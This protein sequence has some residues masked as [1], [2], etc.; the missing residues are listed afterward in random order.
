[1]YP[2]LIDA[3]RDVKPKQTST[4]LLLF[5]RV[6]KNRKIA[7]KR[8]V[9]AAIFT[10]SLQGHFHSKTAFD[11]ALAVMAQPQLRRHPCKGISSYNWSQRNP[12]SD[13]SVIFASPSLQGTSL[14]LK[15]TSNCPFNATNLKSA[16]HPPPGT[17]KR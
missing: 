6:P 8:A 9:L 13:G 7:A 1:M 2:T 17:E 3:F 12:C 10:P 5:R 16:I 14:N 4:I 11:G 15:S